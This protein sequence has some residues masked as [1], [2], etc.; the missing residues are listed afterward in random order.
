MVIEMKPDA[1]A[2]I[3]AEILFVLSLRTK[4]LQ[5]KAGLEL[6]KE[7]T[8]ESKQLLTINNEPFTPEKNSSFTIH[9]CFGS[10]QIN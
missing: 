7:R 2:P 3:A 8:G 6:L 10:S 4:R 5:R 9:N 1:L